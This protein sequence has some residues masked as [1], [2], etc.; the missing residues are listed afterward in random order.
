V[1]SGEQLKLRGHPATP[2]FA[3]VSI[4]PLFPNFLLSLPSS[5]NLYLHFAGGLI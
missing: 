4:D 5:L 3:N 1:W 2:Q